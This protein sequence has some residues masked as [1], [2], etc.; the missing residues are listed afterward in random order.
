MKRD[1]GKENIPFDVYR[2]LAQKLLESKDNRSIWAH[3]YLVISWNLMCRSVNTG[4]IHLDKMLWENDALTVSFVKVK[5]DQEGLN[6]TKEP[7]HLYANPLMP[8]ICPILSL[9]LYLVTFGSGCD[10]GFLFPGDEQEDRFGN[11]LRTFMKVQ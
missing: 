4:L 9:G 3:L 10:N 7:I 6:T 1:E 5:T 8:E 2:K 11:I